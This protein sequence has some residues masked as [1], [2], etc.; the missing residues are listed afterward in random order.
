MEGRG[1][2]TKG[3]C[4]GNSGYHSGEEESNTQKKRIGS[5][6]EKGRFARR[7]KRKKEERKNETALLDIVWRQ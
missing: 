5:T 3:R 1:L 7:N 6:G 2:E 4:D